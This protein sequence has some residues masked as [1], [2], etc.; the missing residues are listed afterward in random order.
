MLQTA[1]YQ[2]CR[3]RSSCPAC[4]RTQQLAPNPQACQCRREWQ[5]PHA[6]SMKPGITWFQGCS[7]TED[8]GATPWCY[9]Q[10]N[11]CP[12]SQPSLFGYRDSFNRS[13]H[14]KTC[15]ED[16]CKCQ[17]SWYYPL[18]NVTYYGC[19]QTPDGV[20]M[21]AKT[22][23]RQPWCYVAGGHKCASAISPWFWNAIA[24]NETRPWKVPALPKPRLLPP[25]TL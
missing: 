3:R 21:G 13:L 2:P 22:K 15:T 25:P 1:K 4:E 17:D 6:A 11:S 16:P 10:S 14:W 23:F 7:T 8:M 5:Y 12:T 18:Y 9:L 20:F 24:R 19:A